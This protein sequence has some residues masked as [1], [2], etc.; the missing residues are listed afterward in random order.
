MNKGLHKVDAEY[1]LFLNSGDV[2]CAPDVLA[3]VTES[4]A[5]LG[6][7]PSLLY[8]DCFEVDAHGVSHLRRARPAW[9]AWL[10]MSTTHQAMYFRADAIHDGYDTTYRLSA[11]YAAVARL[12]VAQRGVDFQ[13]LPKPL[14]RFHLGGRSEQQRRAGLREDLEIRRRVLG[15]GTIP[16]IM[17]H[18]AHHTHRWIKRHLPRIHRLMRYG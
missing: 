7:R 15:M 17:L 1:V 5:A 10:G 6:E 13:Y 2:L 18:A 8:G 14:C 4:I 11:D 3:D 9:W 12:Y 16:A